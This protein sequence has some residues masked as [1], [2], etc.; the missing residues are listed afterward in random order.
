MTHYDAHQ[1]TFADML[2]DECD[3]EIEDTDDVWVEIDG[4]PDRGAYIARIEHGKCHT[5]EAA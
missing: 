1:H 4:D 3:T 5:P 2:C